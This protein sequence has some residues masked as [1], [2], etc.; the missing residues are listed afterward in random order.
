M[1]LGTQ[2]KIGLVLIAA[3]G[4]VLFIFGGFHAVRSER[5]CGAVTA[6]VLRMEHKVMTDDDGDTDVYRPVYGFTYHDLQYEVPGKLFTNIETYHTGD[7][8]TLRINPDDPT[9]YYDPVR[10][11][12]ILIGVS[13]VLLV[14]V[15]AGV[16]MLVKENEL[17]EKQ[18][19]D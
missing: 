2:Q 17:D 6:E 14:F 1:K 3:F 10:S 4:I 11:R 19:K 16:V 12:R 8:V 5:C 15:G 9:E 13:A 18:G 7:E